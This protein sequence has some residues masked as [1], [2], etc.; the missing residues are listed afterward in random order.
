MRRKWRYTR[1]RY[2]RPWPKQRPHLT[3]GVLI[4]GTTLILGAGL[5]IMG[6]TWGVILVVAGLAA[7]FIVAFWG[8][9]ASRGIDPNDGSQWAG[10]SHNLINTDWPPPP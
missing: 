5:W 10:A 3:R 4:S 9:R 2:T 6:L 7:L 1:W 8:V